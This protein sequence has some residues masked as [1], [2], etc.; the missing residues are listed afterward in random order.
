MNNLP[1]TRGGGEQNPEPL[2]AIR[3]GAREKL[4][5]V[6]NQPDVSAIRRWCKQT[7]RRLAESWHETRNDSVSADEMIT[8]LKV[9]VLYTTMLV[10]VLCDNHN[11]STVVRNICDRR[12]EVEE[13]WAWAFK[14]LG[15]VISSDEV[16]HWIRR[17]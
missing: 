3:P 1:R 10:I 5:N 8:D 13:G 9:Q 6:A 4:M 7:L 14:Q 17:T 15:T 11:A 2:S 12:L 16:A